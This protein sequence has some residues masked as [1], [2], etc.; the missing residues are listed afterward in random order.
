MIPEGAKC[1]I[2]ARVS[3]EE[4]NTANQIQELESWALRRGWQVVDVY[5][6]TETAWKAGHQREW[7]RLR[8]DARLREFSVVLVW[9]LDRVTRQGVSYLFQQIQSLKQYDVQIVS[10][11]E[12]W[13]E[14]IGD[15]SEVFVA[16]VG[17]IS[18]YESR[19]RSE[20]TVAGMERARAEGIHLGRP[21]GAR[22][23]KKRE[24]IG[25]VIRGARQ[26]GII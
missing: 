9:A 13:I 25:Y 15:L 22:D 5:Q 19:R 7:A 2:Y 3:T 4:Q 24:R 11:Q 20:R 16:L 17:F 8:R 12:E 21:K 18:S 26:R 14:S 6:E 10:L 23:S 1:A